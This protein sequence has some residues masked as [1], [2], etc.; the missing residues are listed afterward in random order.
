MACML[1]PPCLTPTFTTHYHHTTELD[2]P[3]TELL[4]NYAATFQYDWHKPTLPFCISIYHLGMVRGKSLKWQRWHTLIL[5]R[6]WESWVL[7][8][9]HKRKKRNSIAFHKQRQSRRPTVA[10]DLKAIRCASPVN[11]LQQR[12]CVCVFVWMLGIWFTLVKCAGWQV[13]QL[14]VQGQISFFWKA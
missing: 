8:L 6:S 5:K 14:D 10:T 2:S 9:R 1:L 4:T 12:V 11:W 7:I 13:E 3:I